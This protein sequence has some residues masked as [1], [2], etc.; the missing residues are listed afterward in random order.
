MVY[1]TDVF[2]T[3]FF[4]ENIILHT[5]LSQKSFEVRIPT[6]RLIPIVHIFR[7]CFSPEKINSIFFL[8]PLS[9]FSLHLLIAV[10]Q[11]PVS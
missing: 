8:A 3:Y 6:I 5:S 1:L 2:G 11:S 4:L 10:L 9:N 7:S